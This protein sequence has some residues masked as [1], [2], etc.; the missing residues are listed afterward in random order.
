MVRGVHA[1]AE[2]VLRHGGDEGGKESAE[3]ESVATVDSSNAQFSIAA[4]EAPAVAELQGHGKRR[5]NLSRGA[6]AAAATSLNLT[7][8]LLPDN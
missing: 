5:H 4:V 6:A 8:Y 2:E 7:I 3:A 1:R